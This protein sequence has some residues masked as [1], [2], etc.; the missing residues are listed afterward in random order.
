MSELRSN[1]IIDVAGTA[2]LIMPGC[3]LQVVQATDTNQQTV[4]SSTYSSQSNTLSV[5]ITPKSAS[6]KILVSFSS[7]GYNENNGQDLHLTIFRDSTNIGHSSYG[8][9]RLYSNS[10]NIGVAMTGM[11]LDEPNTTSPITYQVYAKTASGG[12]AYYGGN[13]MSTITAME[14]GV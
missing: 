1:R 12:T 10:S 6:N 9:S 11:K 14:V 13:L 4:N 3:I 2:S 7:A 5:T 8:L